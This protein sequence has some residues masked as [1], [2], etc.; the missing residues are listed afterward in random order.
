VW[1]S[2]PNG[3]SIVQQ[4]FPSFGAV[5]SPALGV[6]SIRFDE[7]FR[8]WGGFGIKITNYPYMAL[9]ALASRKAGDRLRKWTETRTEHT[10]ARVLTETSAHF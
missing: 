7:E 8:Y 2:R 1:D 4:L 10:Q 5:S 3:S 9:C 6:E